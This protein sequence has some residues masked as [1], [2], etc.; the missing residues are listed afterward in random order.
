[1]KSSTLTC[2][3]VFCNSNRPVRVNNDVAR[4]WTMG[5]FRNIKRASGVY[6]RLL[7]VVNK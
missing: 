4:C 3:S 5:T 1:M 6:V 7:A 2:S